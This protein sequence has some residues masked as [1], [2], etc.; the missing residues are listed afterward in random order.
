MSIGSEA[1]EHEDAGAEHD[2]YIRDIEYSSAQGTNPDV[3]EIDHHS[4]SDS[5]QEIGGTATHKQSHS[6]ES[7]SGPACPHGQYNQ[8]NQEQPVPNTEDRRSNRKW[9]V[10]TETE[11]GA[12]ILRVLQTRRV[13]Q[14]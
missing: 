2:G 6:E 3:H 9:P 5:I 14:E 13:G 1:F 10:C 7:R 4:I 11:E 12:R 8:G